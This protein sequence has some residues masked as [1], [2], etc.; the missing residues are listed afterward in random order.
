MTG[1]HLIQFIHCTQR[2]YVYITQA[3]S[4][5]TPLHLYFVFAPRGMA[6]VI[7]NTILHWVVIFLT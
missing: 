3:I 2:M 1:S 6:L 7:S 5:Y 4:K